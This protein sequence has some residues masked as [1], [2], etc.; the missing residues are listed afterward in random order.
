MPEKRAILFSI[1]I[2][3]LLHILSIILIP[4]LIV[5]SELLKG[6]LDAAFDTYG[7][8][9]TVKLIAYFPLFGHFKVI[10]QTKRRKR[11]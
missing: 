6:K 9:D 1:L 3:V 11:D 7:R 4:L 5:I 2:S 8:D 10:F